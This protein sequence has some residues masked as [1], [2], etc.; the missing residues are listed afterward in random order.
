MTTYSR[1]ARAQRDAAAR[2][3]G[4][5]RMRR[6]RDYPV[7]VADGKDYVIKGISPA[8]LTQVN[9]RRKRDGKSIRWVV[10]T[11]LT[12]YAEGVIKL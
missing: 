6:S 3:R 2:A 12:R 4:E 8:L 9:T 5:P 1:K 7:D 11:L 10:L